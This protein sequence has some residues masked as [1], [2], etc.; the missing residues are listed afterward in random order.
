MKQQGFKGNNYYPCSENDTVNVKILQSFGTWT[1]QKYPTSRQNR[2]QILLDT[3]IIY[4]GNCGSYEKNH[5]R[6]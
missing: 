5:T 3:Q 2:Q 1:I 4:M 6:T